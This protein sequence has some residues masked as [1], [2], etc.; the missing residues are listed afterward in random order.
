MAH[1]VR[2][3]SSHVLIV[4]ISCEGPPPRQT[5]HDRAYGGEDTTKQEH[6]IYTTIL[7]LVR[8]LMIS[9][10]QCSLVS[11]KQMRVG[12]L[13]QEGKACGNYDKEDALA[14]TE[15]SDGASNMGL[16]R[17][18][19]KNDLV[20]VFIRAEDFQKATQQDFQ[21]FYVHPPRLLSLNIAI[22]RAIL[23]DSI[24][25]C[26]GEDFFIRKDELR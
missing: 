8:E 22:V 17:V 9:S 11:G 25:V 24:K 20:S 18:E 21:D 1:D 3:Y 7:G 23:Q 15:F 10:F 26:L 2:R 16:V 19:E 5:L 4:P 12:G 13:E 6:C 14:R